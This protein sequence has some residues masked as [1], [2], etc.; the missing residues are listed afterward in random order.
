MR[1]P[2]EFL[3][4]VCVV[5][6]VLPALTI[7]PFLDDAVQA[8]LGSATPA[9]SLATWHGLSG[10]LVMSVLALAGG[11]LLYL[12]LRRHL[13][14]GEERVPLLPPID[15]G[16]SFDAL[17]VFVSW[18][19]ARVLE[20]A[21]GTRRLQPQLRWIVVLAVLAAAWP[22]Q[23]HGL[24][25][26]VPPLALPDAGL[27]LAWLAGSACAVAAAW[28]AKYHR[29][30]ALILAGVA[31]LV[32]CVTFVWFSAPDLAI[33]QLLVEIVTTVLLLLGLRWLPQRTAFDRSWA[34]ARRAL[35]RRTRD[36]AIAVAAGS[37]LATLAYAAMTRP[38]SHSVADYFTLRALPEG[39]GTNVVNVILVDFR[40]FDTLGEITVLGAVAIAVYSLLRR[41][42][43]A[44]ESTGVPPQQRV[45]TLRDRADDLLV[46]GVIMRAMFPATVVLALYLLLRGHNLPGGGFVAGITLAV[47]LIVQYMAGG[48]ASSRTGCAS[49]PCARSASDCWSRP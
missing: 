43:P 21:L 2:I 34:S 1:A 39:G 37:G 45:H 14:Q 40:A 36:F 47:A 5:V 27:A 38:L 48:R 15:G 11:G 3:V 31:G 28:Q 16:R 32:T 35:P 19:F 22:V 9:Y 26:A 44:R 17:L 20:R 25:L 30:F 7:G 13:A 46:P 8:V 41:F 33:T 42:R 4:L 6:G 12:A 24:A 29:L 49:V 18:R 10:P 23:R